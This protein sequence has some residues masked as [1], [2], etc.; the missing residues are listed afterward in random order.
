MENTRTNFR[1]IHLALSILTLV[2]WAGTLHADFSLERK[3]SLFIIAGARQPAF[4]PGWQPWVI[5]PAFSMGAGIGLNERLMLTGE[6]EFG[7]V[8]NDTVSNSIYKIGRENADRYWQINTIKTRLKYHFTGESKFVPYLASGIGLSFWSIKFTADDEAVQVRDGNG[9]IVDYSATEFLL[10]GGLGCEWFVRENISVS[11]DACLNYLT[12]IG[13]DFSDSVQDFRSRA[14]GDLKF[15]VSLYFPLE[16]G[17]VSISYEEPEGSDTAEEQLLEEDSD[18]DGVP[19]AVDLCP[20]TPP[21]A[22]E[23]VDEHGCPLDSDEDGLPDYRDSCPDI[24]AEI[25]LDST[26]CPPDSD[27][28]NVPDQIDRCSNTPPGYPVDDSGCAIL[29]SI[30]F[31]RTMHVDFS[32]SGR[33]IDFRSL[34][35]LDNIAMA[36]R[37]FPDVDV[38][39]KAYTDNTL[40][41]EESKKRA[42]LEAI[43]IKSY[44]V[45]RR[46]EEGRIR[47][48]GMGATDF[49]DTNTSAE[50]RANNRRIVIE[51]RY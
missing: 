43:K 14:Y 5:S 36:M 37:D 33:G 1:I 49:I 4:N 24:F 29:D 12:G 19:D 47:A 34:R 42:E 8:Y 7:K 45:E 15:G 2:L 17:E 3:F 20:D 51:F 26:G 35:T 30:F 22:G 27:R 16:K 40:S 9:D 21:E 39:V 31:S 48:V 50:G 13:A 11:V 23:L 44:L 25:T 46:V 6:F 28:D 32:E 38:V 10:S 41:L 18:L